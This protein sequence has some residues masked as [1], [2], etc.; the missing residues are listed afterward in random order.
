MSLENEHFWVSGTDLADE[1][2]FIWLSTGRP[3]TFANWNAGEP[4]NYRYENGE[5]ENCME[6]WNRDGKG[7]K[8]NDS[9]FEECNPQRGGRGLNA[10]P[11]M[12]VSN[13]IQSFQSPL[14]RYDVEQSIIFEKPQSFDDAVAMCNTNMDMEMMEMEQPTKLDYVCK[15]A[16]HYPR[17]LLNQE[18]TIVTAME[19]NM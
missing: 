7:L 5:E 4:N 17:N 10:K 6:L 18:P 3:I 8:W 2:N 16:K 13:L 9:P 11:K 1:G 14:S 12:K 15:V 19:R